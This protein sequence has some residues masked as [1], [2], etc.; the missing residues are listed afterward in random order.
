MRYRQ[1]ISLITLSFLN[2]I[3]ACAERKVG[4]Q[5][6]SEQRASDVYSDVYY[7][8][9][10]SGHYLHRTLITPED[11]DGAL[12]SALRM[13]EIFQAVGAMDDNG[14]VV[15][16]TPQRPVTRSDITDAL[17]K[18]AK[19]GVADHALNPLVLF[20]FIGQGTGDPEGRSLFL[21]PG[22]VNIKN[23]VISKATD[24]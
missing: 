14:I 12:H 17:N 6:A 19:K 18:I 5:E 24:L 15:S 10:A 8:L 3:A 13:K 9:V 11:I 16:S 1:L 21:L 7:V 23:P 2:F 20:Y 4:L 22:D